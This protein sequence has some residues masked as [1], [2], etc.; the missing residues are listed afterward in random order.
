M[1]LAASINSCWDKR[2]LLEKTTLFILEASS[3]QL[4]NPIIGTI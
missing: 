4:D 3:D 1:A 2:D